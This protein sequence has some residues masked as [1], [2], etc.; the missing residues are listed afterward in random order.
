MSIECDVKNDD[1]NP[2]F[3][4]GDQMRISKHKY[5]FAKDVFA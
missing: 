4:V 3:K 5:I 2:K 1:K